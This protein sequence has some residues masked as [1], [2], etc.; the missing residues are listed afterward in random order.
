M[1]QAKTKYTNLHLHISSDNTNAKSTD[2]AS[3]THVASLLHIA[4]GTHLAS[5]THLALTKH[6]AWR[7]RLALWTHLALTTSCFKLDH[8]QN[9]QTS[10]R[11]R[12]KGTCMW[13][14]SD[15]AIMWTN[16]QF[17]FL[18]EAGHWPLTCGRWATWF[19]Q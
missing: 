17:K 11:T 12:L 4:S 15:V 19:R 5:R 18:S 1:A 2:I 14:I 3:S 7:T 8:Q 13:R 6:P 9:D 10:W 16:L